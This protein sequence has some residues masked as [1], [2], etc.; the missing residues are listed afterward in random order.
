MDRGGPGGGSRMGSPLHDMYQPGAPP[1]GA[2]PKRSMSHTLSA[3]ALA[4]LASSRPGDP[5]AAAAAAGGGPGGA[6]LASRRPP[7]LDETLKLGHATVVAPGES[8]QSQGTPLPRTSRSRSFA[9]TPSSPYNPLARVP[10]KRDR[11]EDKAYTSAQGLPKGLRSLIPPYGIKVQDLHESLYGCTCQWPIKVAKTRGPTQAEGAAGGGSGPAAPAASAPRTG[12]GEGGDVTSSPRSTPFASPGKDPCNTSL[13]IAAL[14]TGHTSTFYPVLDPATCTSPHGGSSK[15]S[16]KVLSPR[17][18]SAVDESGIQIYVATPKSSPEGMTLTHVFL[19][20]DNIGCVLLFQNGKK[21][22]HPVAPLTVASS[23]SPQATMEHLSQEVKVSKEVDPVTGLIQ[24]TVEKPSMCT[25]ALL[26]IRHEREGDASLLR[27]QRHDSGDSG[28]NGERTSMMLNTVVFGDA[29]SKYH[30]LAPSAHVA[31]EIDGV[32]Y[33]SLDHFFTSEGVEWGD[34]TPEKIQPV[35]R[36]KID[37]HDGCRALLLATGRRPLQYEPSAPHKRGED[38]VPYARYVSSC[39]EHLR[40]EL[41]AEDVKAKSRTRWTSLQVSELSVIG[42]D[43]SVKKPVKP[44]ANLI[45][46]KERIIAPF[47]LCALHGDLVGASR[48]LETLA[49]KHT[50]A[51]IAAV[52]YCWGGGGS[53]VHHTYTHTRT[54]TG[55]AFRSPQGR[56]RRVHGAACG[57]QAWSR[58]A[59]EALFAPRV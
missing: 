2:H 26:V 52:C 32:E 50:P 5:S 42:F 39:L 46:E 21:A 56:C 31:M 51:V 18:A 12:G 45:Q 15:K 19:K 53:L 34:L 4:Q 14:R 38:A 29:P 27:P 58:R 6:N 49:A 30:M 48:Q 35:L 59:G 54:R 41:R 3:F 55:P 11:K 25:T 28:D 1:V 40:T 36:A 8:A 10:V 13:T 24:L 33:H 37:Q 47:Y 20:G 7:A 43:Q 17:T 16:T 57:C 23:S 44:P 22:T 9:H